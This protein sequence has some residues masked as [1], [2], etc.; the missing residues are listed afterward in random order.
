MGGIVAVVRGSEWNQG[1]P[2]KGIDNMGIARGIIG[3]PNRQAG[4]HT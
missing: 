4:T 3:R 2:F 1:G